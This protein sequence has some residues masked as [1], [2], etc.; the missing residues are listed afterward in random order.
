MNVDFNAN[1]TMRILAKTA[2]IHMDSA[3]GQAALE[4]MNGCNLEVN[5]DNIQLVCFAISVGKKLSR[6]GLKHG[7]I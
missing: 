7:I 4:L 1:D 6:G 2:A 5:S 3:E